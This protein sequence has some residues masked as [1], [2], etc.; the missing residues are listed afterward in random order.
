[1]AAAASELFQFSQEVSESPK[2]A[3]TSSIKLP[4][5]RPQ[6]QRPNAKA[7]ATPLDHI[8]AQFLLSLVAV[9]YYKDLVSSTRPTGGLKPGLPWNMYSGL[10]HI[11]KDPLAVIGARGMNSVAPS[12]P[13]SGSNLSAAS[14][15][16][17]A[18]PTAP[19]PPSYRPPP[20]V[21]HSGDLVR[22]QRRSPRPNWGVR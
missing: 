17:D 12:S 7:K 4:E 6:E 13:S 21:M 20:P 11:I 9:Q 1:M 8:T 3:K 14:S 10:E 16:Y 2:T 19:P 18:T 22:G 15:G 5:K